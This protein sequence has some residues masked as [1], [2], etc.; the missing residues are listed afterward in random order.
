M[1]LKHQLA[2]LAI[3]V[4]GL[5]VGTLAVLNPNVQGVFMALIQW[6]MLV[7]ILGLAS[8]LAAVMLT[9]S[10]LANKKE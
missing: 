10:Y 4:V 5:L 1:G 9:V 3:I 8:G 7:T 2:A 6:N